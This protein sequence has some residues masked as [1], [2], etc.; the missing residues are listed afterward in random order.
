[1]CFVFLSLGI[2]PILVAS[3]DDDESPNGV[4]KGAEV[5]LYNL[6]PSFNLLILK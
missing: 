1:M 4:A 6:L 2:L 5:K 3:F